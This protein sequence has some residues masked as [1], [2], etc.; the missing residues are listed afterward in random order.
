[1]APSESAPAAIDVQSIL[2]KLG[3][4]NRATAIIRAMELSVP[5]AA[6]HR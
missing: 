5:A 1:M 4:E 3:V 2:G 6:T